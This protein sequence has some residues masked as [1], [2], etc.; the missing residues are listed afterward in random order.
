M[1]RTQKKR[2]KGKGKKKTIHPETKNEENASAAEQ[3]V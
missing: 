3:K 2:G 1:G